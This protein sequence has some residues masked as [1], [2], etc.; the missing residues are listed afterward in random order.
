MPEL[1]QLKSAALPS[2]IFQPKDPGSYFSAQTPGPAPVDTSALSAAQGHAAVLGSIT[3]T[4]AKLP[5]AT[6][7]SYLGGQDLARKQEGLKIRELALRG[8]L[9]EPQTQALQGATISPDGDIA[10]KI[11][12]PNAGALNDLDLKTK[13]AELDYTKARARAADPTSGVNV[14]P[15]FN[16]FNAQYLGGQEGFVPL[17]GARVTHYGDPDDKFG[18]KGSKPA[19]IGPNENKLTGKSTAI[20]PDVEEK[21]VKAGYK[22]G[23]MVRWHFA[24]GNYEDRPWDDRVATDKDIATIP[25]LKGLPPMRGKVDFNAMDG[26]T[27]HD[28]KQVVGFSRPKTDNEPYSGELPEGETAAE[29]QD[30]PNEAVEMAYAVIRNP[31]STEEEKAQARINLAANN[32]PADEAEWAKKQQSKGSDGYS[33]SKDGIRTKRVDLGIIQELPTGERNFIPQFSK[34]GKGEV[35]KLNPRSPKRSILIEKLIQQT[36]YEPKPGESDDSVRKNATELGREK[37]VIPLHAIPFFESWDKGLKQEPV[38]KQFQ[39]A[40]H[41]AHVIESA[42]SGGLTPA[43]ALGAIDAYVK[44]MRGGA[45]TQGMIKILE[46]AQSLRQQAGLKWQKIVGGSDSNAV[47]TP[48]MAKDITHIVSKIK[49]AAQKD[50]EGY[51]DS[52]AVYLKGRGVPRIQVENRMNMILDSP[53]EANPPKSAPNTGAAALF[54]EQNKNNPDPKIQAQVKALVERLALLGAVK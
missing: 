14:N 23:D 19:S 4:I 24:D 36:G 11:Q 16:D 8:A 33:V 9:S 27:P 28:D 22:L 29:A 43:A 48:E 35:V 18:A 46:E 47:L 37:E 39:I 41:E 52:S 49:E 3:D 12:N 13:Q 32:A 53:M 31:Q 7:T 21:L 1:G 30:G 25:A 45:A 54:V 10:L 20:S 51:K 15:L 2:L 5:T 50:V 42:L 17:D 38:V 44:A 40:K 34:G 26:I 6:V